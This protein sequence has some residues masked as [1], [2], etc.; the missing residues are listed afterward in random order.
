MNPAEFR[1]LGGHFLTVARVDF[2]DRAA[3]FGFLNGSD[4][5]GSFDDDFVAG[6]DRLH[7]SH[8]PARRGEA[9]QQAAS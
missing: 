4:V 7:I 3:L 2:E 9:T 5:V 8:V 1:K 6:F